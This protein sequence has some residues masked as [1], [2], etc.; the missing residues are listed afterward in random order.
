[1]QSHTPKM[2]VSLL[3]YSLDTGAKYRLD[4]KQRYTARLS[5]TGASLT[6]ITLVLWR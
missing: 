4:L 5:Q 1:M 2:V 6:G 3:F